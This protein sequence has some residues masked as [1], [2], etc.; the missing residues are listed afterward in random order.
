MLFRRG[1]EQFICPRCKYPDMKLVAEWRHRRERIKVSPIFRMRRE[2][3]PVIM[4]EIKERR[5]ELVR[6]EVETPKPVVQIAKELEVPKRKSIWVWLRRFFDK[7]RK[8]VGRG[9]RKR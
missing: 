2:P 7:A 5:P 6:K 8:W 4:P 1:I 9:S 3:E